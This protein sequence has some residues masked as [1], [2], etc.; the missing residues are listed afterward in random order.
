MSTQKVS[1]AMI[2]DMAASKLSGALPALDGSA[3]TGLPDSVTKNANDPVKL[4]LYWHDMEPFTLS[5]YICK[6]YI[7]MD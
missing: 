7:F 3:L 6:F 1:D 5:G 4:I 2:A